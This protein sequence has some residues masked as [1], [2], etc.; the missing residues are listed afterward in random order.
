MSFML[1]SCLIFCRTLEA[2]WRS[3]G[4]GDCFHSVIDDSITTVITVFGCLENNIYNSCR[5]R[6]NRIRLVSI[7]FNAFSA[8]IEFTIVLTNVLIL[9]SMHR[10][11]PSH[12]HVVRMSSNKYGTSSCRI[13]PPNKAGYIF[14][15]FPSFI[16]LVFPSLL[17]VLA[18]DD[19]YQFGFSWR[20]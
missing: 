10:R 20:W 5:F 2:R 6:C 19:F 18:Q 15:C 16:F 12:C 7:V 11:C 4:T 17:S 13:Y 1:Y 9:V 14:P 3:F 8:M